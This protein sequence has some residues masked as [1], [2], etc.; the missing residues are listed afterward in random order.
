VLG[1]SEF[2]FGK[3]SRLKEKGKKKRANARRGVVFTA[4][5]WLMGAM[6]WN[7]KLSKRT[8]QIVFV[9]LLANYC[10]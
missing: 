9:F 6:E 7:L 8:G 4:I 1:N 3:Y 2:F 5:C 10:L